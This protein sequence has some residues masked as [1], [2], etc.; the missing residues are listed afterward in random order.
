ML[1]ITDAVDGFLLALNSPHRNPSL[2]LNNSIY[3][4]NRSL[5]TGLGT[6]YA[7]KGNIR[8]NSD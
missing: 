3:L 4:K 1:D 8:K 5:N 6:T 2:T 7:L